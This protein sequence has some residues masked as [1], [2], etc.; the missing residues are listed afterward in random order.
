[1]QINPLKNFLLL[2][3]FLFTSAHT[4]ERD[5]ENST[6]EKADTLSSDEKANEIFLD[7][8]LPGLIKIMDNYLGII[9]LF[10]K[11]FASIN[12]KLIVI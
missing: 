5:G 12:L 3:F 10:M 11:E 6:L 7:L 1:M 4:Q 8:D 9:V 2:C